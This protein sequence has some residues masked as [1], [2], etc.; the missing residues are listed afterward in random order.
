MGLTDTGS[1]ILFLFAKLKLMLDERNAEMLK[2]IDSRETINK[3]KGCDFVE[4]P[5]YIEKEPFD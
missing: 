2:R 4:F 5:S 3:L 1:I